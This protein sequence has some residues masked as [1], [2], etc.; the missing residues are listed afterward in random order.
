MFTNVRRIELEMRLEGRPQARARFAA[1]ACVT[2]LSRGTRR[3]HSRDRIVHILPQGRCRTRFREAAKRRMSLHTRRLHSRDQTVT[4]F[5]ESV[6][7]PARVKRARAV[8][9]GFD[10]TPRL[11]S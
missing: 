8:S 4:V 10:R 11:K 9:V 7:A 1:R 6:T 2:R 5:D 3:L